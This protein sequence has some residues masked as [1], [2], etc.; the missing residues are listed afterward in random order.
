LSNGSSSLIL[1]L[2]TKQVD[3]IAA[4][5]HAPMNAEEEGLNNKLYMLQ[6][7]C[8]FSQVRT[9]L[10]LKRSLYGFEQ[11]PRYS[12]QHLKSKLQ[13]YGFKDSNFFILEDVIFFVYLIILSSFLLIITNRQDHQETERTRHGF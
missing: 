4:F 3:F 5:L 8:V 6:L 7:P 12:F 13:L 2:S 10:N 9:I 11:S 1:S